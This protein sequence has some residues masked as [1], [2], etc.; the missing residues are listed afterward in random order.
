MYL[1]SISQLHSL[2]RPLHSAD[3]AD[4]AGYGPSISSR[5]SI[6]LLCSHKFGQGG[7]PRLYYY[8]L[9][10]RSSHLII[11]IYHHPT[12]ERKAILIIMRASTSLLVNFNSAACMLLRFLLIVAATSRSATTSSIVVDAAVNGDQTVLVVSVIS[13]IG[14]S[15]SAQDISNVIFGSDGNGGGG[16]NIKSIYSTCSYGKLNLVKA[17]DRSGKGI[18]IQNGKK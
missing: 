15:K 3:G 12:T 17:Q 14:N 10:P 18:A 2:L 4:E 16:T 7:T 13:D 5:D 1:Q 8:E 11:I 6:L 9:R